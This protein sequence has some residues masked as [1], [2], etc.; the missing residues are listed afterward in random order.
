MQSFCSL[1]ELKRDVKGWDLNGDGKIDYFEF[2]AW[3]SRAGIA[4]RV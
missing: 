3:W 2:R 1:P 4:G